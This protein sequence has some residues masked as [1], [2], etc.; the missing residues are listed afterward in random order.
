MIVVFKQ[1][2]TNA[3]LRAIVFKLFKSVMI[4]LLRI[5]FDD[6]QTF[7]VILNLNKLTRIWPTRIFVG[8]FE[9]CLHSPFSP[10]WCVYRSATSPWGR[11]PQRFSAENEI[12]FLWKKNHNSIQIIQC[13]T[14]FVSWVSIM[15]LWTCFSA[16]DSSIFRDTTATRSAVHPAPWKHYFGNSY[17]RPALVVEIKSQ[18]KCW[19]RKTTLYNIVSIVVYL[20]C[21]MIKA[22]I[23]LFMQSY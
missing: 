20:L 2:I 15:K 7:W 11:W 21:L 14:R 16:L 8:V 22:N 10:V 1:Y 4:F 6:Q 17:L 5:S 9:P 18:E 19:R 12:Y 23:N 13:C 3:I